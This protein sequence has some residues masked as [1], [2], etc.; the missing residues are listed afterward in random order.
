MC[1]ALIHIWDIPDISFNLE[2]NYPMTLI[3]LSLSK[4]MLIYPLTSAVYGMSS[5]KPRNKWVRMDKYSQ[6][7]NFLTGTSSLFSA[8]IQDFLYEDK[9]HCSLDLP[10]L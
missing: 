2:T 9:K 8:K 6:I 4:K 7:L 1:V 5:S 3:F 10:P